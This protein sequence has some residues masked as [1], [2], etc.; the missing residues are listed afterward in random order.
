M[1]LLPHRWP[2]SLFLRNNLEVLRQVLKID[3]LLRIRFF[4]KIGGNFCGDLLQRPRVERFQLHPILVVVTSH[5]Q[6]SVLKLL[7]TFGKTIFELVP[8]D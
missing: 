2:L 8:A 5:Y 1:L 4:V 3:Y 6:V 7:Q